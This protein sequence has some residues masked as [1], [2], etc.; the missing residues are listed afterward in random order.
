M[1]S[2]IF[3][4][5]NCIVRNQPCKRIF[6]GSRICFVACPNSDEIGLELDIIKQKLREV[7][8]EPYIAVNEREL[9]KDIFCEK[10]CSKIIESL[11]CIVILND[12][13]DPEDN[14]RK[15][16]ANVYYEYG[17]MTSFR[18]HIIPIQLKNQKLA[19]NIQSLDTV[20]YSP[21]DF[22]AQIQDAI[23]LTLLNIEEEKEVHTSTYSSFNYEW[24]LDLMGLVKAEDRYFYR[25]ERNLNAGSLDF[26]IY[27]SPNEERLYFVT[28][29]HDNETDDDVIFRL[30]I[31]SS[32]ISNYC[33]KM[34]V[35]IEKIDKDLKNKKRPSLLLTDKL[36]DINDSY[37]RLRDSTL[38][39]IKED[40]KIKEFVK[41][42]KN[43]IKDEQKRLKFEIINKTKI[44]KLLE[45]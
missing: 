43:S 39:L 7:N 22:S 2:R 9:Q 19:F 6:S 45:N 1:S 14:I 36:N 13:T 23:K 38:L 41:K 4:N 8:I 17:L 25:N 32:R 29:A 20:K 15:P 33:D 28:V 42:Y 12:V 26:K 34:V 24:L 16:N 18:K 31:M 37:N 10:I 21:K 27:Y 35:D 5:E 44:E 40:A 3:V 11:F 30:K